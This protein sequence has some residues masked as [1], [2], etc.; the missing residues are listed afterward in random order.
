M[1]LINYFKEWKAWREVK[2]VYKQ[3]QKDFNK[4]GLKCDWF[5]KLWKVINRYPSIPLGT[6]EDEILLRNEL[7]SLNDFLIKMNL[8]DILAYELKPLEDSDEN[9]FEN[10]YLITFTPCYRLD[11]QYVSFKSTFWLFFITCL[12]I[13]GL[14]F[15][16]TLVLL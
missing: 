2:K 1:W 9:S 8:M 7:M 15:L 4:I 14:Y 5:G 12:I 13:S 11:K 16:F 6:Q 10:G 3:N